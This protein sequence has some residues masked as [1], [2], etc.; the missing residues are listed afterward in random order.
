MYIYLSI[1][2]LSITIL[3]HKA[4]NVYG[5][6]LYEYVVMLAIYF[7]GVTLSFS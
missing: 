4:I 1:H 5:V 2:Y 7:H 6:M 3:S